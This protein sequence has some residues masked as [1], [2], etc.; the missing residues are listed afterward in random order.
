MLGSSEPFEAAGKGMLK[1]AGHVANSCRLLTQKICRCVSRGLVADS[2]AQLPELASRLKAFQKLCQL[3]MSPS[4]SNDELLSA[5]GAAEGHSITLSPTGAAIAWGCKVSAK[6]MFCEFEAAAEM[7][8]V[9]CEQ[10]EKVTAAGVTAEGLAARRRRVRPATH[11]A[12]THA[13]LMC[14]PRSHAI[15]DRAVA[16]VENIVAR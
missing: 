1:H 9:D 3:V 10:V 6:I 7:L 15:V 13:T 5:V 2:A 16:I 4:A 12:M 8:V 14:H 11:R